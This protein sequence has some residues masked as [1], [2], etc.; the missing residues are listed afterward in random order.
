MASQISHIVYAKKLFEQYD[1][2]PEEKDEFI[3]GTTFPD[4]RRIDG[5]IKRRD[6]HL[7][8]SL[9]DLNFDGMTPFEA[10][11]KFHLYCDMRREEILNNYDFYSLKYTNDFSGQAAKMLEDEIAYDSYDNWK[12]IADYFD[13]VPLVSTGIDVP[14]ETFGLWYSIIA[15]YVKKK[16]DNSS[17][18]IFLSKLIRNGGNQKEIVESIDKLRKNDKVIKLLKKVSEEIISI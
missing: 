2:L 11:W 9:V 4:I 8:F 13:N 10:G 15:T 17:I 1:L 7:R 3:L 6:T 16:P 5:D 14:Q 18:E 12:K